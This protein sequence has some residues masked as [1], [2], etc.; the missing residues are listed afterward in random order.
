MN[1]HETLAHAIEVFARGFAFTRSFT[2]PFL[3]E[4][5]GPVWVVRDGSRKRG[6]MRNEEWIAC[7]VPPSEV[8]QLARQHARGKYFICA[9]LPTG[10][11]DE[12]LRTGFKACGYRLLMTE[13]LM[14]HPL[15]RIPR[16]KAP[17]VIKR[18]TTLELAEHLKHTARRRQILPEHVTAALSAPVRAY[19]AM[20]GD[21]IVGWVRSITVGDATWV[22]N[23]YVAPKFRRRSIGRALLG[24]ML[25]DDR[26][27]RAQTSVLLA[28]HAGAKLYPLVGYREIGTLYLYTRR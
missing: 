24:V 22:S 25:R 10:E 1:S 8:D 18:V 9:I 23:M 17:V 3:V 21:Q 6:P 20:S 5:V 26:T 27:A 19:V 12:S 4:R 13:S 15:R 11:A 16:A 7:G 2:H 28:S 14:V